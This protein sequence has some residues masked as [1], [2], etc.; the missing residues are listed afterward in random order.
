MRLVF[1][2]KF[3]FGLDSYNVFNESGEIAFT[4]KRRFSLGKVLE[5]YDRWGYPI[6]RI[7]SGWFILMPRFKM[8][9]GERYIG[10]IKKKNSFFRPRYIIDCNGWEMQG[11]MWEWHYSIVDATGGAIATLHKELAWTDTYTLDVYNDA[12]VLTVLMIVV[13]IDTEKENRIY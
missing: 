6:G 2:E 10:E 9:A 3:T 11:N 8:F 12:D 5:I 1:K 13:A 7:V 4:V